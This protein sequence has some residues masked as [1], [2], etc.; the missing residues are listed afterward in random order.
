MVGRKS[1]SL[2]EQVFFHFGTE[3]RADQLKKTPCTTYWTTCWPYPKCD[4]F[5][6]HIISLQF[7]LHSCCLPMTRVTS[8]VGL[9]PMLTP[10]WII[11][12]QN[13]SN[14]LSHSS[15]P[16]SLAG[17][18]EQLKSPCLWPRLET[19][20]GKS[21]PNGSLGDMAPV[22][23]QSL[24]VL[25]EPFGQRPAYRCVQN[26]LYHYC[27]TFLSS[28]HYRTQK[29][30]YAAHRTEVCSA[31]IHYVVPKLSQTTALFGLCW[32][33]ISCPQPVSSLCL[34]S[35]KV[36]PKY[37]HCFHIYYSCQGRRSDFIFSGF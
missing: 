4:I 7:V 37:Q 1:S 3:N 27:Y 9:L 16:P 12:S 32:S 14:F 18:L 5:L 29:W 34:Y 28:T 25:G 20:A 19:K 11:F 26:P 15:F 13:S 30:P 24:H 21:C 33:E 8:I 35:T 23:P 17:R 2:A 31:N 6:L 22:W 10:F 36:V